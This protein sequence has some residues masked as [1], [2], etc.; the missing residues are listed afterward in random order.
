MPRS[1]LLAAL[2][3]GTVLVCS[4]L[5]GVVNPG[6]HDAATGESQAAARPGPSPATPGVTNATGDEHANGDSTSPAEVASLNRSVVNPA[7]WTPQPGDAPSTAAARRNLHALS[8]RLPHVLLRS[9]KAATGLSFA[10]AGATQARERLDRRAATV[11]RTSSARLPGAPAP[12][13]DDLVALLPPPP[14]VLRTSFVALVAMP[15]ENLADL[16]LPPAQPPFDPATAEAGNLDGPEPPAAPAGPDGA[17]PGDAGTVPPA[18]QPPTP[19]PPAL[20]APTPGSATPGTDGPTPNGLSPSDTMSD[21]SATPAPQ[22]GAD[23][24]QPGTS[25]AATSPDAGRQPAQAPRGH[26]STLGGPSNRLAASARVRQSDRRELLAQVAADPLVAVL[27]TQS[28]V[29]E[30]AMRAATRAYAVTHHRQRQITKRI[31]VLSRQ[32]RA[33]TSPEQLAST[34]AS[35]ATANLEAAGGRVSFPL[36]SGWVDNNNWGRAGSMWSSWH[37]GDDFSIACGTPVYAATAGTISVVTDQAWAGPWLVQVSTG[38][39]R[40]T[41]WYAHMQQVIVQ[42]GQQVQVGQVIGSVGAMGNASGCHL[43]FELH[44]LGGSIYQD[45]TDP[46]PWLKATGAYPGYSYNPTA[47]AH[48]TI[49]PHPQA[50]PPLPVP[51]PVKTPK[52]PKK[53]PGQ[54]PGAVPTGAVPLPPRPAPAPPAGPSG[55]GPGSLPT[56]PGPTSGPPP[57]P[58]QPPPPSPSPVDPTP[59]PGL[60]PGSV[61]GPAVLP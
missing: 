10:Q 1:R 35:I 38:A 24:T 53:K 48:L 28:R 45:S 55:A 34:G 23:A 21:G 4:V 41:T 46:V 17:G 57:G 32:L 43:H 22:Q 16:A 39:G 60:D 36:P 27:H 20:Q 61:P 6:Q 56:N 42:D 18:A 44:P 11:W 9:R 33:V 40:L 12:V 58:A 37:T 13:P 3:S 29:T 15:P 47:I 8:L 26:R 49:S 59:T 7:L 25:T 51:A 30:L 19:Q 54:R 2:L 14:P 31:S 52:P 5:A 50:M